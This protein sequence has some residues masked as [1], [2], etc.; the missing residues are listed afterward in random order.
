MFVSSV[1]CHVYTVVGIK[2]HC[3]VSYCF[4]EIRRAYNTSSDE[5]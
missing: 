1:G 4:S 3:T 5:N 2:T